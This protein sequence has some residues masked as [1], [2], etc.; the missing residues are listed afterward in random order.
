M[1][2]GFLS[3]L[4]MN[5]YLFRLPIMRALRAKGWKVYAIAP[6]GRY[7]DL[8]AKEGIEAVGYEI[9]R[10]SLNPLKEIQAIK[11]IYRTIAPLK[12]DILHTFT[13]KPNIYGT[14]AARWAGIPHIFNLVEGLGSFYVRDDLKAKMVRFVME[15]LY[16]RTFTYAK[17][18]VFVNSDDPKYMIQRGIIDPAKVK[19][20]KSVGIDLAQ[21]D[22]KRYRKID[23]GSKPVVLMVGRAIWDKGVREFYEAAKRLEGRATFVYVGESDP[24]N[25]G[26][27]PKEFLQ[28]GPVRYLGHRDDI[29]DLLG[30]CDLFVLP[31]Y[32]E[33]LPRTLLEAGAMAKPMVAT[34]TVGCRD[35]VVDGVN[36]FLVPPKDS[37][38]LVQAIERLIEDGKLRQKMGQKAR[39]LVEEFAIER[40]VEG[41]VRLYE[42]VV[43]VL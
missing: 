5:L 20:I 28:S 37:H 34:D 4:D 3:H 6:K 35:V 7:F 26:S 23:F 15:G 18:V 12:L 36:G 8:F 13:A 24:G 25:P 41:Y 32:R 10:G 27:V 16:K 33:G 19:I 1:K 38:A 22:P 39:E 30:S 21:F 40:I 14:L 42:G 43:G 17:R 2:I 11:N 31:S 9:D 29:V